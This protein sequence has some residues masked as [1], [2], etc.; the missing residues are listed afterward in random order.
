MYRER[1][2]IISPAVEARRDK[3]EVRGVSNRA[4][5]PRARAPGYAGTKY[6]TFIC[7]FTLTVQYTEYITLHIQYSYFRAHRLI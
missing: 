6:S 3:E 4:H 2:A 5:G 1:R 7:I